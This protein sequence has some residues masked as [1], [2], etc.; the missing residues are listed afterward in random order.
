MKCTNQIGCLIIWRI[1]FFNMSPSWKSSQSHAC[2]SG[3]LRSGSL[4]F[5]TNLIAK[6]MNF[7][8]VAARSLL[9]QHVKCYTIF[10]EGTGCSSVW[11][12]LSLNHQIMSTIRNCAI[13]SITT[14][15]L[16]QNNDM[17]LRRVST[18]LYVFLTSL[19]GQSHSF[20]HARPAK[21]LQ[22]DPKRIKH[23][24]Q[25]LKVVYPFSTLSC[26]PLS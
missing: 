3:Y 4:F 25:Y 20:F 6:A 14:T 23:N 1:P 9:P 12:A 11:C 15:Q 2:W 22:K 8:F 19:F 5:L 10:C 16:S 13:S 24:L 7:P 21:I 17:S 26:S 18:G